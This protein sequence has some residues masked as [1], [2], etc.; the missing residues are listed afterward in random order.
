MLKS[1]LLCNFF[2]RLK[3]A[4]IAKCILHH[5]LNP[6]ECN[7]N[8]ASHSGSMTNNTNSCLIISCRRDITDIFKRLRVNFLLKK[9]FT[10]FV[11]IAP[12]VRFCI[13]PNF[14]VKVKYVFLPRK[15]IFFHLAYKKT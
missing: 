12:I 13:K 6:Y 3:I 15:F 9:K 10:F 5:F 8:F 4:L 11:I 1:T 2:N 14:S 7:A